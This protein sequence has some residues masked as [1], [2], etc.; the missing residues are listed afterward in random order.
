MLMNVVCQTNGKMM[1]EKKSKEY[2]S[3]RTNL[4]RVEQKVESLLLRSVV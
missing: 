2:G 1:A 4:E 3:M